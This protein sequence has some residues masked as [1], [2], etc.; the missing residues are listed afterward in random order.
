[1]FLS[2]AG[3]KSDSTVTKIASYNLHGLN[4]GSAVLQDLCEKDDL[5]LI[6]VQEHWQSSCNLNSILN[7]SPN[8]TGFG[9]CAFENKINTGILIGRP[10]GGVAILVRDYLVKFVEKII[11]EERFVILCINS[12]AFVNVYLPTKSCKNYATL[13]RST[14]ELVGAHLSLEIN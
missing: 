7:F 4:Q 14:I 2:M 10:Y 5:S 13:L 1:M 3:N 9:I 11:C 8:F 6:M 12:T